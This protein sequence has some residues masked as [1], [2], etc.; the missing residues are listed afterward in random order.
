MYRPA[1][2]A[3][4]QRLKNYATT[5]Y[6]LQAA[7]FLVVV[8]YFIAPL[9]AYWKRK[10]AQ[11][12]WLEPHLRWQI[13]TFWFSLAGILTGMLAFSTPLGVPILAATSIWFVYRIGQG[14]ARLGRGQ[15]VGSEAGR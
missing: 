3:P 15:T 10:E 13:N 1:S 12:T 2:H 6:F 4:D 8:T 14:W 5:I 7:A 9:L 11:G